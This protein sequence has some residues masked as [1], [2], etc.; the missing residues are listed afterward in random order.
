MRRAL[1]AIE[2]VLKEQPPKDTQAVQALADSTTGMEL[3]ALVGQ[4]AGATVILRHNGRQVGRAVVLRGTAGATFAGIIPGRYHLSLSTGWNVWDQDLQAKDLLVGL[5]FPGE[6][7]A[8][9]AKT[10]SL[11]ERATVVGT[12]ADG[13]LGIRVI[14]GRESGTIRCMWT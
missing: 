8:A 10:R 7:I 5:A 4:E 2:Q 3:L 13:A 6:P 14:P 11:D 1:T 12:V 9:A